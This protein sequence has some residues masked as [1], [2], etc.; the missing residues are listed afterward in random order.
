MIDIKYDVVGV[1]NAIVDVLS[2]TD[3]A[4]IERLSID[5]GAMTLI[6]QQQAHDLYAEID[7]G[8]EVSGGSAANTLVGLASLGGK[9]AFIGKVQEDQL[10]EVFSHDIR[11][12]GVEFFSSP[13]QTGT[14]TAR[15]LIFVTPDAQRTMQTFLGI[16]GDL[17]ADD[18]D[19]E[20]VSAAKITYLEGYLFDKDPAR[21]AF[22]RAAEFAHAAGRKVTLSLSDSFCVDRH[23]ASFMQLVSNHIYILFANEAEIKSLFE[24]DEIDSV[25]SK[26]KGC[27]DI[28]AITL[29]AEGSLIIQ[30]D[31]VV[32]ISAE[33]INKVVDTTGAGDLYAAGFLYGLVN[34]D[35]IEVCGQ[36]GSKAAAAV[37]QHFGARPIEI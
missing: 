16:S 34:G 7:A 17:S 26:L 31:E 14:S 20:V 24:D 10:G 33:P 3:D 25:I 13:A 32:E 22:V 29:G 30:G 37:I 19:K 18:I 9:G 12:S 8:V 28:A 35:R 15:C 21:E 23:R 11:A 2:R 1:G 5:K 4:T 27:C 36:Y 6:N